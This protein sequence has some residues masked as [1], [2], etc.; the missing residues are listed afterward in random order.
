MTTRERLMFYVAF[1]LYYSGLMRVLHWLHRHS[2]QRLL[3]LNY[4][5]ASGEELRNHLL[6]LRK[7]F[8]LQFLE[9][10]LVE[11]YATGGEGSRS[12]DR[13]LPLAITFDDGYLDNYTHA[14]PLARELQVPITI[15]LI[16]NFI[17]YGAAFWW[18]DHVV[19]KSQVS[20][21]T[22]DKH[23]Y[24]LNESGEQ[25]E[26][27]RVIDSQVS[28][29]ADNESR[30]AYLRTMS[31]ALS[32]P[33]TC[34]A[35]DLHKTPAPLLTWDQVQEM[36]ASGWVA[37]GGHTQ[38]HP[39]LS[40]LANADEAF[41]EVAGCRSALQEKLGK[42][43]RVF[44]YPHGGIQHIGVNGVLA[45]ERAGYRWAVTTLQGVNTAQTYPYLIRRTSANSQKHWL[46][47]ALMTSGLWDF[48]TYFN[49]LVT[50][51]K[52][53][54]TLKKMHLPRRW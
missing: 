45:A 37:F 9:P 28:S 18:F 24:H 25:R 42:S 49:W 17:D 30:Q 38:H 53:R 5:Q 51:I 39:T 52:H 35:A 54:K 36:Q 44:A 12:R 19:E 15:F 29:I 21:V 32:T 1:F 10:A 16:S 13:R 4:H 11:L 6:Y 48:L 27:A 46:L 34:S 3:I 33:I 2:R 20:Q 26:L 31:S 7:H 50:R 14:Y 23:T 43:A 8:R 40:K 47:I 41:K 22:F